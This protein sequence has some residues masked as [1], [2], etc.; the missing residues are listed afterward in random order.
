MCWG[1]PRTGLVE[2]VYV[3]GTQALLG[4]LDFKFDSIAVVETFIPFEA[5]DI[6][7]VDEDVLAAV[8]R[9]DESKAFLDAEPL[10]GS[11]FHS[12]VLLS[13]RDAPVGVHSCNSDR[14]V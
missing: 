4:R 11:C 13:L 3:Q 9:L 8:G 7:V 2:P 6:A 1:I 10:H 12:W 14:A 5:F